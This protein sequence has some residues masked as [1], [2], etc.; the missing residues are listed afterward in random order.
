MTLT[1]WRLVLFKCVGRGMMWFDYHVLWG[2]AGIR[3]L[4]PSHV[5]FIPVE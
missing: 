4:A 1:F 3:A 2:S 5:R